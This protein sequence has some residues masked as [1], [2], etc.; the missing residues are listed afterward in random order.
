MR[1]RLHLHLMQVR[2]TMA[3]PGSTPS[4]FPLVQ[5]ELESLTDNERAQLGTNYKILVGNTLVAPQTAPAPPA[6]ATDTPH[7]PAVEDSAG[8]TLPEGVCSFVCSDCGQ[9]TKCDTRAW[10][11]QRC[12]GCTK[13][14]KRLYHE[15][16]DRTLPQGAAESFR[17]GVM[18]DAAIQKR[19]P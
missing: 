18:N 16:Y 5:W 11:K 17:R 6:S 7:P 8:A 12:D 1:I 4:P 3:L 14:R 15:Q 2:Q 13:K 10:N 9:E 19:N